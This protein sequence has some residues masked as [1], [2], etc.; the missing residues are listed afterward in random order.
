M[1]RLKPLANAVFFLAIV[2]FLSFVAGAILLGG[3][4]VNG[5]AANGHYFLNSHGRLTEVSAE[6]FRYST[7]HAR[8]VMLTHGLALLTGILVYGRFGSNRS[9]APTASL[10]EDDRRRR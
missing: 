5:H 1:S 4:A 10:V 3:D 6:V 2:N 8:S 7:W 9:A